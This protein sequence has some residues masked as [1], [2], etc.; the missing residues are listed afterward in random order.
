M[1]VTSLSCS[2]FVH[3]YNKMKS[4]YLKYWRVIRQW[5]K[6]RYG[7]GQADLDMLLFLYSEQYFT[8]EKFRE[9]VQLVSWDVQ[10]FDRMLRDGWIENFREKFNHRSAIYALSFKAKKMIASI[11][12]KLEGEEI[13]MNAT[14]NP[15]FKKKVK[16][17]DKVYR[18]MIKSMNAETKSKRFKGPSPHLFLE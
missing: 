10:R 8:K 18:N 16:F 11:Y 13:P 2:I 15:M 3:K 5:V 4:D 1:I 12:A 9:F 7:L 14:N 6:V 17:T